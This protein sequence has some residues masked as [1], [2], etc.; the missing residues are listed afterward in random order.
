M[1]LAKTLVI[2]ATAAVFVTSVATAGA[3][4][5]QQDRRHL[6]D[7]TC[8]SQTCTPVG[9]AVKAQ[10]GPN[11]TKGQKAQS[12]AQNGAQ[13]QQR[14]Q[15]GTCTTVAA[16]QARDRQRVKDGTCTTVAAAQ[17]R[18]RQRVKDGTCTTV[19]A[20]QLRTHDKIQDRLHL[21]DGSCLTA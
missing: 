21:Q 2:V 6:R 8:T 5:P 7:A 20:A 19:A 12:G 9:D 18:D 13:A 1:K 10:N 3:A 16:A 11:A 15:D 17:A 14:L 4:T